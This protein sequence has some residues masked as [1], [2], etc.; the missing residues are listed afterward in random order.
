MIGIWAICHNLGMF[1]SQQDITTQAAISLNRSSGINDKAFNLSRGINS[2]NASNIDSI[3][4]FIFPILLLISSAVLKKSFKKSPKSIAHLT[5]KEL[6][7]GTYSY[8]P[9]LAIKIALYAARKNARVNME[10]RTE[11]TLYI[12]SSVALAALLLPLFIKVRKKNYSINLPGMIKYSLTQITLRIFVAEFFAWDAKKITEYIKN[13]TDPD[14]IE[15]L[16][17]NY[18]ELAKIGYGAREALLDK[19]VKVINNALLG[20][21]DWQGWMCTAPINPEKIKLPTPIVKLPQL[22]LIDALDLS[23]KKAQRKNILKQQL[24][25]LLRQQTSF[26]THHLKLL[27]NCTPEKQLAWN[28]CLSAAEQP[29]IWPIS[30]TQDHLNLFNDQKSIRLIYS[31][32]KD[33]PLFSLL[34]KS[35]KSNLKGKF[36]KQDLSEVVSP[37]EPQDNRKSCLHWSRFY[38]Q[39][40]DA[41]NKLGI[42]ERWKISQLFKK[43]LPTSS[44]YRLKI[45]SFLRA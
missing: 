1:L 15:T 26:L 27:E 4:G 33:S 18:T 28:I 29:Q 39:N 3:K 45:D 10:N 32:Y 24:K 14:R 42:F 37:T 43:H 19:F 22:I 25:S 13:T 31:Y 8:M 36:T 2:V 5:H 6:V 7:L 41:W 23:V 30:L 16:A 44:A 38:A 35:I 40:K 17:E 34:E 21:T 20:R 11:R 12:I 9:T